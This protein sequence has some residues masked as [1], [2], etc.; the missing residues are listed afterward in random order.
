MLNIP[1]QSPAACHAVALLL[2]YSRGTEPRLLSHLWNSVCIFVAGIVIRA[3]HCTTSHYKVQTTASSCWEPSC[4]S[5]RPI[6]VSRSRT[7]SRVVSAEVRTC[8]Q[9]VF[10]LPDEVA[11]AR[12]SLPIPGSSSPGPERL[13]SASD[14][15]RAFLRARGRS[16]A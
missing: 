13:S 12:G 3:G 9:L 2:P 8:R 16:G 6:E 1:S 11:D 7:S 15:G 4:R 10:G 5:R 14:I